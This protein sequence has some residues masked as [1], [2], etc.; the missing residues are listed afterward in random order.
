MIED[1]EI[2]KVYAYVESGSGSGSGPVYGPTCY[3]SVFR[4][5]TFASRAYTRALN[6]SRH[7]CY[8]AG[9]SCGLTSSASG[10]CDAKIAIFPHCEA[11]PTMT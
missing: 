4:I 10:D 7:S 5:E 9:L 11:M 6:R 2:T 1:T 8:H 3:V